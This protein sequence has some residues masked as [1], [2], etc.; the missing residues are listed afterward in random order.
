MSITSN[1]HGPTYE[2]NFPG[3]GD[4][5]EAKSKNQG[6]FRALKRANKIMLPH[7][8][9]LG[10]CET[11]LFYAWAKSTDPYTSALT[12]DKAPEEPKCTEVATDP[13][14]LKF[15]VYMNRDYRILPSDDNAEKCYKLIGHIKENAMKQPDRS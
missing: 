11:E 3:L 5:Q 15:L 2:A 4:G 13:T 12:A 10:D 1:F 7:V 9:F 14:L 8:T 6:F